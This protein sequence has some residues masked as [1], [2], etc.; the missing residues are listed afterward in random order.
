MGGMDER[1]S[2]V[3]LR[4]TFLGAA[5]T[6]T[7]SK[8][9]VER[10]DRRLL[11]AC[12]LFQGFKTLRLRNWA[13]LPVEARRSMWAVLPQRHPQAF[14]KDI[15]GSRLDHQYLAQIHLRILPKAQA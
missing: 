6:V 3:P 14:K 8:F 13:A 10:D 12:G 5:G 7:G 1:R 9:L 2:D 15:E 11:V 4:L